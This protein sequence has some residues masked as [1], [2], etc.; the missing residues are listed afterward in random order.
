MTIIEMA[1]IV[2]VG[3]LF[4]EVYNLA[5]GDSPLIPT[6]YMIFKCLERVYSEDF[7]FKNVMQVYF[8]ALTLLE[9]AEIVFQ[10]IRIQKS[11]YST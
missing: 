10:L 7:H 8:E 11:H 5:K 4:V 9:E 3:I 2:D 6:A 1:A